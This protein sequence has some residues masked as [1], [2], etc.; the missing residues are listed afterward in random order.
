IAAGLAEAF[1][2][3]GV[4]EVSITHYRRA[5]DYYRMTQEPHLIWYA[6]WELGRT[7]YFMGN[8][9]E[10]LTYFRQAMDGVVKDGPEAAQTNHYLGSIYIATGEYAAALRYL[11]PALDF[12]TR[13]ANPKEAAQV[14]ALMGQ[15]YQ[16]QGKVE[17]ARGYYQSALETFRALSD[18]VNE[19]ATLYALG[20]RKSVV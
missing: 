3:S 20:D 15:I 4:P 16:Q 8:N 14:R 11:Q 18:R 1:R 12:Y 17:R 19:S 5:L 7:Y 10:A 6:T 13:A 2:E 9:P